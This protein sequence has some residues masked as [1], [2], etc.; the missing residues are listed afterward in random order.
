[1]IVVR[2]SETGEGGS[3]TGGVEGMSAELQIE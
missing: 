3:T 1:M 2:V